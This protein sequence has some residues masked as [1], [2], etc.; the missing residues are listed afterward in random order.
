MTYTND[1]STPEPAAVRP[2]QC[3]PGPL[4]A[5]LRVALARTVRLLRRER[6]SEDI[7]DG[8]YA[9]LAL[10]DREGP[11]TP[12]ALAEAEHVQPPSMTRMLNTLEQAGLL[13]RAD[14]PD[15]RRQVI[16]TLS[17]AG[18]REVRETR[19]R[20]DAWLARRLADLDPEER[21]VLARAAD[22]LRRRVARP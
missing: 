6:S 1:M 15:D 19:R 7:T 14:D 5:E 4:A 3:R 22:I 17:D 9:V 13:T 18:R 2:Q 11:Q 12:R 20:R 16:V 21:E 8:Q 10:L